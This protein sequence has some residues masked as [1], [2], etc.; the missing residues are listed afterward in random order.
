MYTQFTVLFKETFFLHIMYFK[1]LYSNPQ[2]SIPREIKELLMKGHQFVKT[3]YNKKLSIQLP[4]ETI[5]NRVDIRM[6]LRKD[7]KHVCFQLPLFFFG[8]CKKLQTDSV[9][10]CKHGLNLTWVQGFWFMKFSKNHYLLLRSLAEGSI[11]LKQDVFQPKICKT[12][13]V[14]VKMTLGILK[15]LEPW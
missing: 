2:D 13:T 12:D 1:V 8:E 11:F 3:M 15:L 7:D 4:D 5:S 14:I 9:C 10:L 6:E